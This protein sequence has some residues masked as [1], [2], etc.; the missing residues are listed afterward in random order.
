M[1]GHRSLSPFNDRGT[2]LT[3]QL[4]VLVNDCTL[5]EGEQS[6]LV[7]I[8]PD[9]KV[10]FAREIAGAGI[11]QIQVGYPGLS[12]SDLDVFRQLKAGGVNAALEAVVLGYLPNWR[13][14]VQAAVEA[15]ADVVNL[16]YVTSP[17]RREQIFRASKPEVKDRSRALIELAK[18][19]GLVVAFAP[20][21]TTRTEIDFLLEMVG[22][23]E[24]AGADR[25][26]IA[27]TLGAAAPG[28]VRWL[29]EQV[30]G[31]TR[32]PIE[33]HGHND[34]G[35]VL[36]NALA[37]VE[38]GA[39]IVDTTLN[40]WGDRTGNPA[41]EE[42][43]AILEL[44]YQNPVGIDLATIAR[45]SREVATELGVPVP[46]AKPITG[47]LA[48][49][50]KLETHVNAV[51]TH[52]PAFEP[53]DPAIVGGAR[54]VAIGQYSGPKAVTAR[55]AS[56]GIRIEESRLAAFVEQVQESARAT[57]RVLSDDDLR[58][59]AGQVGIARASGSGRPAEARDRS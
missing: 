32:L 21:D 27:D 1:T 6:A 4:D 31:V 12:P 54:Q 36:A 9:Q 13:E 7:N 17:P 40:G 34:F 52:P 59:L 42:F 22:L 15:G 38:A 48:F 16:C 45:L 33:F 29:V 23:A 56:L 24:D 35:L 30:R 37:A 2:R 11:R 18:K 5:R 50:H 55:M 14:Q 47:A 19:D 39:T 58:G 10:R 51:L 8:R 49:A 3:G 46:P 43:V 44:L 26:F 28:A 57:N 53:Y 20:A 25:V 41:T